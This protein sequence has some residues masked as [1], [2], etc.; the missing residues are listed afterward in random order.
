MLQ[1][2]FLL[3]FV[4]MWFDSANSTSIWQNMD[5]KEMEESYICMKSK[6]PSHGDFVVSN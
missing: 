2:L 1:I 3:S 5:S 6:E 4:C